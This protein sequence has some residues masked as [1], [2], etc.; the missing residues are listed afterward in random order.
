MPESVVARV[1]ELQWMSVSRLR[2][3]WL[4]VFDTDPPNRSRGYLWRRLAWKIQEDHYAAMSLEE[5]ARVAEMRIEIDAGPPTVWSKRK[6]ERTATRTPQKL[7]PGR[8]DPRLPMPGTVISRSYKGAELTVKVL[9]K[10]FEFE[11]R[12]YRS[13]SAIAREVTGTSWNGFNFFG[14]TEGARR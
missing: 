12:V 4:A 2:E 11:G 14:L 5:R 13:L 6:R 3:K 8:R 9:D 7:A 10:G 1:K